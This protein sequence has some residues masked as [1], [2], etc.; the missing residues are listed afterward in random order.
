MTRREFLK[1]VNE[2]IANDIVSKRG[3]VWVALDDEMNMADCG[4]VA[5][6]LSDFMRKHKGEFPYPKIDEDEE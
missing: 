6:A 3:G 4:I 2:H 5:M 1:Q